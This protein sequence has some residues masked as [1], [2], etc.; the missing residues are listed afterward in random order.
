MYRQNVS[1]MAVNALRRLFIKGKFSRVAAAKSLRISRTTVN[2]YVAEFKRIAEHYP[3]KLTDMT[4]FMPVEKPPHRP[5][6]L[7]QKLCKVLPGLVMAEAGPRL[8]A[9]N[10]WAKYRQLEPDGYSYS[11][12]KDHFFKWCRDNDICLVSTKR[13]EFI[14]EEDRKI[15]RHW[16]LSNDRGRWQIAVVLDAANTRKSLLKT[17]EKIECCFSTI[18]RW[19]DIYE[20]EGLKGFEWKYTVNEKIVAARKVKMDNLVHL[21]QQSPK[22]YGIQKVSWTTTD[23]GRVHEQVYGISLSQ[24]AVS[25]YLKRQGICFRRAREVLTSPD[26]LYREKFALIQETLKNLKADE[27]FFSIDEYGPFSVRPKGGR[28]L[29][30]PGAR[31]WYEQVKTGKGW[32]ICT[33]ALELSTNQLTHFYSMKKDTEEMIKLIELLQNRY[34]GQE[35]LYLSWDAASWH[36]SKK[37]LKHIELLNEPDYRKINGTPAIGLAPLP[38]CAQFLN[39]IESV[40]SGM[41]KSVIRNSDYGSVE[42]C[43]AAID[44]YFAQ[45]NRYFLEN[46]KR[47]GNKIWGKE[48]VK[49]VFDKANICKQ[50]N[51]W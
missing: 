18:L 32:F 48:R 24:A 15:L 11:P 22:I 41:S 51:T 36:A 29:A 43:K 14:P 10:V 44:G 45:R 7:Y 26:P 30:L 19:L 3:E 28:V 17:A 34:K 50:P 27:K 6:D 25:L 49:P 40:F 37:L 13:I 16:R 23:L 46:P 20:T 47:A 1:M 39:V 4:F 2:N 31:P 5:T 42:D 35:K 9:S 21:L 38:S 33:A 8:K 12:F